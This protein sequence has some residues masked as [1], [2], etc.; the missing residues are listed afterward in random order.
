LS[1]LVSAADEK[2]YVYRAG[3][4]IGVAHIRI[5]DP[6]IPI[7]EGV[8]SVLVGQGDLDDPWLPGK[9]A[10]RW[11]NVHGGDTPDAETEE[12]AA[13]RIQIPLYFAAVI[14]EM[15]EP[16]TTLVITNLAAAPHTKS[17]S[18]F[19]VIAAQEG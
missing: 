5:A 10:H 3:I 16:G 15:I 6:E 7:D 13:N 12:Q 18:G 2:I 1:L 9:P 17:E 19:V 11:L 4:E 8:F 14:Y